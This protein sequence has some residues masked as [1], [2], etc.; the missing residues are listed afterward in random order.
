MRTAAGD[1]GLRA[2][3]MQR[4]LE[5]NAGMID[6]AVELHQAGA[7]P[8]NSWLLDLDAVAENAR[9][10]AE[11]AGSLGLTTYLMTKQISRNP[12]VTA[13]ALSQGIDK[14]VAVDIHCAKLLHRYGLP[15]GH[16]GH[17]NQAPS[18][19]VGRAV[20]MRPD[21][22]TVYSV[23]AAARISEEAIARGLTQNLLLRVYR[24]DDVFFP[25]QEGGF[26][27]AEVIDAARQIMTFPNVRIVGT[28]SFPVL[29]YS[30]A[31]DSGLPGFNPNMETIVRT[32][33]RLRDE[34]GLDISVINAPGNTSSETLPML[35]EAGATHVEPG[36]GLFGTTPYQM[37]MGTQPEK[38]AYVY[39]SEISHIY[40]GL[41]YA[42][43]GGV[44]S[45]LQG[46]LGPNWQLGGFVGSTPAAA[47]DNALDYVH[48]DQIID[49]HLA[50]AEGD[51]CR[52]G[53]TVVFPMYTQAQM[54]RTHVVPVSGI[55]TGNLRVWGV[56]DHAATML[57]DN[58]EPVPVDAVKAMIG[59]VT[60][61]YAAGSRQQPAGSRQE[62]G[63]R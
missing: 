16:I 50:L 23:E 46:F 36:H 62:T 22:W 43:G 48:L 1:W 60:S 4:V 27:E 9:L 45:L 53:D 13:V 15:V 54:T 55:S 24:P 34:L 47:R 57:D 12:I 17:L 40:E 19:D 33:Q 3:L 6:A 41:G 18:H 26:R 58:Y 35:N 38:P 31:E 28:T 2:M 52:I 10:I 51:R 56:F 61:G 49:Y 42:F 7:V 5:R 25:G 39:V 44:W 32:A 14:T 59:E 30:F 8:A 11:A 37:V 21:L 20:E 29:A 63:R